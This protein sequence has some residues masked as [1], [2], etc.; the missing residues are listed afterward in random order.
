M[1]ADDLA[2]A[3]GRVLVVDDNADMRAY[4]TRLLQRHWTV[5]AV[6]DGAAA[7]AAA[8]Q[9]PPDLV[10]TDVMMPRL[11]GFALLRALRADPQTARIPVVLLSARAGEEARIEGV[12]AGADDYLVKPF[13]ARELVARI[14]AQMRLAR[15]A[16][17]RQELLARERDARQ[18]A[19][20]QKQHLY[21]LFMQAPLAIV[22]LRGPD[23]VIELANPFVCG[24]WGRRHRD[25]INRP[26]FEAL[27]E[28]RG[29]VWKG[30]LDEVYATGQAAHRQRDRGAVPAPRRRRARHPLPRTSSTRRCAIAHG[31]VDGVLVIASDVTDQVVA[32][33]EISGLR[34]AA[35]AANRAKDEFLAM[36]GHELRNP[37]APILTA[38]Q[39]LKLRGV[40]AAERERGDHRA[41]G[42]APGPPGRRSARRLAHHARQDRAAAGAGRAR[43]R[44]GAR[45]RDVEPAAR[46]AA[47]RPAGRRAAARAGRARRRRRGWRRWSPTC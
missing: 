27:P 36:L 6:G 8:R 34:E 42:Q 37:L 33:R 9:R 29:Q 40:D 32:R 21:S 16:R 35:E 14:N 31:E 7:L 12:Q 10:L 30:L 3:P 24:I 26:L 28:L 25:V 20:L 1:L 39:L 47:A 4:L 19:D 13:S 15:G 23:H 18:E 41:P 17:E 2:T 5:E 38:L 43:R 11:D 45:D 22:V 44:R 46:A